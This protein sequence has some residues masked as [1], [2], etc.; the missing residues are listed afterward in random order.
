MMSVDESKKNEEEK[1]RKDEERKD[2][3]EEKEREEG[4]EEV[5]IEKDEKC[6]KCHRLCKDGHLAINCDGCKQWM[7]LHCSQIPLQLCLIFI[8]KTSCPKVDFIGYA[9]HAELNPMELLKLVTPVV[10][11]TPPNQLPTLQPSI[12]STLVSLPQLLLM[13][14]SLDSQSPFLA[15]PQVFQILKMQ[16]KCPLNVYLQPQRSHLFAHTIKEEDAVMVSV[17]KSWYMV[18]SAVSFIQGSV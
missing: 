6:G 3:E 5:V 14:S 13:L 8:T 7:H 1:E 2:G 10:T 9:Y 17:E 15:F 11:I 4:E 18:K 16:V 12:P